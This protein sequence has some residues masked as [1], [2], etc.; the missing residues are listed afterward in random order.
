MADSAISSA[1]RNLVYERAHGCCEYCR[2]Q[3]EYSTQAFSIEH[4]FPKSK[5][6]SN[7]PE[8][9]ALAC[10]GCNAHKYNKTAGLDPLTRQTVPL[11]HPRQ[12][13][14]TEHFAW[15][16]D[17]SYL[18]GLSP[19]GRVTISTLKLNRRQLVN[20]RRV[21]FAVGEHPPF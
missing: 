13:I 18:I 5:G 2:S 16:E 19:S 4:I 14:W 10:Q 12:Q 3:S 8:N 6:G 15:N 7:L 20:L 17:C 11:F 21:L 1:L 9:L